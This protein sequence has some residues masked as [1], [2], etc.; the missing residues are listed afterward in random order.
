MFTGIVKDIG[1][2]ISIRQEKDDFTLEIAH[3]LESIEL[4]SSVAINGVCLTVTS[5]SPRIFQVE[6][7]PET[8]KR[9]NIGELATEDLVNLEPALKPTT[10]LGGHFVQGHIDTTGKLLNKTTDQNAQLLEF[11]ITAQYQKYI[12]EKGSIAIDGVSLTVIS[13]KKDSFQ[14]GIIPYTSNETILGKLEVGQTVNLETDIL[15]KYI[16]QDLER[17]YENVK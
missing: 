2:V 12:V 15:G 11:S 10:E 6:V 7:M 3:H 1:R 9:T 16:Y 8:I 17:G 14:V 13:V 5:F 4:G